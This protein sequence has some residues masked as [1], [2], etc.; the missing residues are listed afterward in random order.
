MS[1]DVDSFLASAK[2]DFKEDAI[3]KMNLNFSVPS[4]GAALTTGGVFFTLSYDTKQLHKLTLPEEAPKKVSILNLRAVSNNDLLGHN[5]QLKFEIH[6]H[7]HFKSSIPSTNPFQHVTKTRN[8]VRG[9]LT[10]LPLSI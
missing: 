2:C 3:N 5:S 4:C 7:R 10:F 9:M 8:G 6:G 1:S